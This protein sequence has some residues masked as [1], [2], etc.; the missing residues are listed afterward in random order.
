M[1]ATK[2]NNVAFINA[3]KNPMLAISLGKKFGADIV[4]YGEAFSERTGIQGKQVTCRARVEVR[5]VRTDD[6]TIIAAN[7]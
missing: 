5:A 7:G 1:F 6:A 2:E 3:S 4:I